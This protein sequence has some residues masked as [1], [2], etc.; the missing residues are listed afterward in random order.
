MGCIIFNFI[1]NI[2]W[3]PFPQ[4]YSTGP[5]FL[6]LGSLLQE[7]AKLSSEKLDKVCVWCQKA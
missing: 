3:V 7:D 4:V 2:N 1:P 5:R 6:C